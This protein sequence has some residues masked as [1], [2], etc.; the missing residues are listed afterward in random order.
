M[1]NETL[2]KRIEGYVNYDTYPEYAIIS[3]MTGITYSLF[4]SACKYHYGIL[5]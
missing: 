1:E 3:G 2:L 5:N 4:R